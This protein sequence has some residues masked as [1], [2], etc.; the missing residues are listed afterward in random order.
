MSDVRLLAQGVYDEKAFDRMP[1][2]ADA[3]QDEGCDNEAWLV[4]M[5][6]PSW[7]WCRGCHVLDSLLPDLVH[8]RD[9]VGK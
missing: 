6:D 4:R 5:R 8:K 2:L 9:C 3:L 1:I 7:P